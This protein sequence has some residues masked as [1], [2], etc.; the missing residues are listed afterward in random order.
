MTSADSAHNEMRSIIQHGLRRDL[1]RVERVVASLLSAEQR[2]ALCDQGIWTL[3]YLHHHQVGE[4]EDV[5][6]RT[7]LRTSVSPRGA[8]APFM[9]LLDDLD[10]R[11]ARI[12]RGQCPAPLSWVLSRVYRP[13][14]DREAALRWGDLTG[15]RA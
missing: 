15:S 9:W 8:A 3:D 10:A 1:D 14:Y 4:D 6:T 5:W 13:R 12:V 2:E 7:H 11:R